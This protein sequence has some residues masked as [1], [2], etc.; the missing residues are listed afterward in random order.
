MTCSVSMKIERHQTEPE[1]RK[2]STKNCA[3]RHIGPLFVNLGGIMPSPSLNCYIEVT[4]EV[5]NY[6]GKGSNKLQ[7]YFSMSLKCDE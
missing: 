5:T 1:K 6:E 3:Q 7:H 2:I 4:S